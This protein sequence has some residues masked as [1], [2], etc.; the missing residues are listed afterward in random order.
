[1]YMVINFRFI[2]FSRTTLIYAMR[3]VFLVLFTCMLGLGNLSTYAQNP[4]PGKPQQK[5]ILLRGATLHIGNGQVIADGSILFDNGIIRA[6][7]AATQVSAPSGTEVV[8]LNGKHIFPGLISMATTVGLQEVASVRATHDFEEVGSLNPHVRA[9]VAYDT[10]SEVIPTLRNTGLLV[11]Q[12]APQGGLVSGSSS[13]F[14]TDGWN[15]GDAALKADDGIWLNWPP[16]LSRSFNYDDFS[17]TVKRNERRKEIITTLSQYLAEAKAY[18]EIESP[19]PVNI[20]FEAMKGLFTGQKNLYTRASYA[21]DI[22]E[23]IQ[24]AQAAGV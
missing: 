15:W 23:A 24:L 11:S 10:D 16:F 7:G 2:L 14:Y 8:E 6:I 9:L 18:A 4:A 22:V 5:P 17:V 1:M 3:S 12:A 20:R 19:N 13:T 21:T